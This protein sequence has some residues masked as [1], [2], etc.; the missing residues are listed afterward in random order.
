MKRINFLP[1]VSSL[2]AL[3]FGGVFLLYFFSDHPLLDRIIN[4]DRSIFLWIN[5]HHNFLLDGVMFGMAKGTFWVPFYA[6]IALIILREFKRAS[7]KIFLSVFLLTLFS[8]Q[9]TS[10]LIGKSIKRLRPSQTP[11]IQSLIHLNIAQPESMYG[12]AS[13]QASHAIALTV[14]LSLALPI[15]YRSC[16]ILLFFWALLVSYSCIYN[17]ENFPLD[18]VAGM[19]IGAGLGWIFYV[20]YQRIFFPAITNDYAGDQEF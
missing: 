17:G 12:F 16:K 11:D 20:L 7:W 19:L 1:Y 6:M 4:C 9:V 2:V 10:N 5:G 18:V 14:F 15:Q 13:S 3:V 8:D